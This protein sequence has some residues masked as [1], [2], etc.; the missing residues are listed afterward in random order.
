[1]RP[2]NIRVKNKKTHTGDGVYV[3][4]PTP[5]GNPFRIG[6]D[7]SRKEVIEKYRQWLLKALDGDNPPTRMF[8]N[9]FDEVSKTGELTLICWCAPR[10]CH[11]DIIKELLMEAWKQLNYEEEQRDGFCNRP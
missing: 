8:A 11:A 3:G 4:R 10:E 7:G 9:L 2:W 5:L 6:L 1:M